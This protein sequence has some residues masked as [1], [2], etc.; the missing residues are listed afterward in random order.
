MNLKSNP[1]L[2]YSRIRV[3]I[4]IGD[5]SSIGPYITARAIEKLKGTNASFVVIG[6]KWVI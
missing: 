1:T 2:R 4:T 3:G 6:D 5:P